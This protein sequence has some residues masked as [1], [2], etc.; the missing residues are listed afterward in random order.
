MT[1]AARTQEFI[2]NKR[3]ALLVWTFQTDDTSRSTENSPSR[4]NGLMF[5]NKRMI[6]SFARANVFNERMTTPFK[7]AD[8][9]DERVTKPFGRADD[10]DEQMTEAVQTDANF[11]W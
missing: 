7:R 10:F 6:K 1:D 2:F 4:S 3:V 8:V 5:I 9:F 11:F